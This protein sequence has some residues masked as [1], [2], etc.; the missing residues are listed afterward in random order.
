MV[1]DDIDANEICTRGQVSRVR[2]VEETRLLNPGISVK[3]GLDS[4]I[5]CAVLVAGN[6]DVYDNTMR[7]QGQAIKM[8]KARGRLLNPGISVKCGLDSNI[9]CAVLV[10]GN[11]LSLLH[12]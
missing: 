12:S 7:G 6:D 5:K 11:D 2:C 1:N 9:K 8:I 10:A 3:C 4:N